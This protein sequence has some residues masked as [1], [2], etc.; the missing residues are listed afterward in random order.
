MS[1]KPPTKLPLL[2]AV[3]LNLGVWNY[4]MSGSWG[5]LAIP[6]FI[7]IHLTIS[8]VVV[9]LVWLQARQFRRAKN[10]YLLLPVSLLAAFLPPAIIIWLTYAVPQLVALQFDG[11]STLLLVGLLTAVESWHFWLPLGLAS[12]VLLWMWSCS[13]SSRLG[14]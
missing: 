8:G 4:W 9:L 12:F 5:F 7:F 10:P 13:P 3:F 14:N 11:L 2:I 6:Y 1:L